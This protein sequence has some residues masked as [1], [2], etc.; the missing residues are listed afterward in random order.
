MS[1]EALFDIDEINTLKGNES[2]RQRMVNAIVEKGIPDDT[3]ML[4]V[5]LSTVNSSDDSIFKRK[6]LTIKDAESKTN[7]AAS[8]LVSKILLGIKPGTATNGSSPEIPN[9]AIPKDIVPGETDEGTVLLN[10]D[11]FKEE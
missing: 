5:L 2:I 6:R 7:N 3:E 11:D 8:E 1:E 10:Y 9:E 4:N